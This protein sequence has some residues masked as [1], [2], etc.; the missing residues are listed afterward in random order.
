MEPEKCDGWGW[1][2]LNDIPEPH[3]EMSKNA[4]ECYRKK[5]FYLEKCLS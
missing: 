3:F 4:I 1:Y 5:V 2:D